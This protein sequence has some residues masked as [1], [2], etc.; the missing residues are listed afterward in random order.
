VGVWNHIQSW[1]F[2]NIRSR[3]SLL[4]CTNRCSDSKADCSEY[5]EHTYHA[6]LPQS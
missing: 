6:F 3:G 4:I 5:L 1:L 2:G